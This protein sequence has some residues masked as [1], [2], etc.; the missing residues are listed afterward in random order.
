[1]NGGV[2]WVGGCVEKG[3][4]QAPVRFSSSWSPSLELVRPSKSCSLVMFKAEHMLL[5][6]LR[7]QSLPHRKGQEKRI[8]VGGAIAEAFLNENQ[9]RY[10]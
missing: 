9:C 2:R 6:S 8:G 4:I 7:A 1:M 5:T 10:V 3:D